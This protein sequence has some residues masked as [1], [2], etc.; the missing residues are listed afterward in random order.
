M[1][2]TSVGLE[3]HPFLT[4]GAFGVTALM[5]LVANHGILSLTL[6]THF[7]RLT[8]FTNH[9]MLPT[10]GSIKLAMTLRAILRGAGATHILRTIKAPTRRATSPLT[11]MM[12]PIVGVEPSY[13]F[14]TI[15]GAVDKGRKR[16]AAI[17]MIIGFE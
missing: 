6:E 2:V 7:N 1:N 3:E 16:R 17:K 15:I 5:T 9:M 8:L 4:H 13:T 11:S 10:L 12:G 14:H